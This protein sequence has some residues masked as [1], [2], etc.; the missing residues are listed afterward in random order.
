MHEENTQNQTTFTQ[1]SKS[2]SKVGLKKKKAFGTAKKSGI[3]KEHGKLEKVFKRIVHPNV[4]S[5]LLSPHLCVDGGCGDSLRSTQAFWSFTRGQSS[6]Q[7]QHHGCLWWNTMILAQTASST[8]R[9]LETN[10]P[11]NTRPLW[12]SVVLALGGII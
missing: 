12:A 6:T 3:K 7:C 10:S 1:Q 8:C 4:K 2:R 5:H 9:R 11:R